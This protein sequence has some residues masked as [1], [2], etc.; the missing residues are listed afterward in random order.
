ML[1][2]EFLSGPNTCPDVR[3]HLAVY[4]P[5]ATLNR[6]I[7]L[8]KRQLKAINLLN[9]SNSVIIITIIFLS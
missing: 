5:V 6:P 8:V 4:M 1:G 3:E 9:S 7:F 2:R